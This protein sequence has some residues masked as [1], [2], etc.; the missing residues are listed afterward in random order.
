M[1]NMNA[2]VIWPVF[3]KGIAGFVL[4]SWLAGVIQA[5]SICIA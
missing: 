3:L 2:G 4:R 1:I 5:E